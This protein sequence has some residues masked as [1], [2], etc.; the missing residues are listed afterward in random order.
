MSQRL[1]S[2]RAALRP[3]LIP[4]LLLTTLL[5]AAAL[6]F[7]ALDWD[8]G[9]FFHPDERAIMEATVKV[10]LPVPFKL[11]ALLTPQSPL[12]PKFF[13]YGSLPFYLT[14]ATASFLGLFQRSILEYGNIRLVGRAYSVLFDLGTIVL[15][16]LLGKKLYD[17]RAG[18]LAAVFV[19]FSVLHIQLAH[20][21]AVDGVLTFFIVLAVYL[22]VDVMRSGSLGRSA[23]LGASVGLALASKFSAAPVL[24][25]VVVAWGIYV[26]RGSQS[27]V[28]SP[29]GDK[30]SSVDR[31]AKAIIG[32]TIAGLCFLVVFFIGEPYAF[33]DWASFI[34]RILEEAGHTVYAAEDGQAAL[35]LADARTPDLVILDIKM[36][37][38]D[39]LEAAERLYERAPVPIIFLT[40]YSE[41]D[42][43]ERAA[44]LP[45]MGY[46]VKPLKEAELHAMI[47]VATRRFA[48]HARAAHGAAEAT[49][50]LA[51]RRIVDRA[52]GLIMQRE[53][54]SELEAYSRL[55]QRA[56]Q[57]RHTLLEVAE[58]VGTELGVA[59]PERSER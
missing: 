5:V 1:A 12:N 21:Y 44:K 4:I 35:A 56:R 8:R 50:A 11:S 14:K 42:L 10:G 13:A 39:G 2:L 32:L 20:F 24:L 48:E 53:G 47:E 43:I 37:R 25:T 49:A 52:K 7:Y 26:I 3:H 31:L 40:A 51:E 45:V 34:K 33:I 19:A 17:R 30:S 54:V 16:Y 57:E 58:E 41:R 22:A 28:L 27:A 38:M 23:L 46:L 9:H 15:I 59:G 36:P 18:L 29:E 55:E 6:R